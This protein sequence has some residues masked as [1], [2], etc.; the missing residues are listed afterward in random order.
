MDF[1]LNNE[2]E[3]ILHNDYKLCWGTPKMNQTAILISKVADVVALD[4][5]QAMS[6]HSDDTHVCRLLTA[7]PFWTSLNI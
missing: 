7:I 4:R 2:R 3:S 1:R 6:H 5:R